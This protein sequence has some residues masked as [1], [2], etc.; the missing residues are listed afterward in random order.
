MTT[1]ALEFSYLNP[2]IPDKE[3]YF[4]RPGPT[5]MKV[6]E[7]RSSAWPSHLMMV[8]S[9]SLFSESCIINAHTRFEIITYKT[10][11]CHGFTPLDS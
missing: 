5:D 7:K 3:V 6:G 10:L 2:I 4:F 9:T 1:A 8:H 11:V